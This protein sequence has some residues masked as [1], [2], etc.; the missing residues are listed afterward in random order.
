MYKL[1]FKF[2]LVER[3][4]RYVGVPVVTSNLRANEC[5]AFVVGK[6]RLPTLLGLCQPQKWCD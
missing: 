3:E 1:I 6:Q 4:T 5:I 2:F